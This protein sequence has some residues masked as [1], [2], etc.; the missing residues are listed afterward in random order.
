[1]IYNAPAKGED[2]LYFV[3][4]LNDNKR[5]CLIQLNN[6]KVADV[7]GEV[8]FELDSEVNLKKIEDTDAAN[9]MAANE[10]CETW[11]GK[12]LSENVVKGAYTSS[13]ADGQITGD[14]IEAT[15]IFNAQQ[16]VV[17]FE[18]LQPGKT[19]NV[20]LE[21]AGLWFAKKAFGS[22]WNVVQVKLHP[23]PILDVYPD[24]YAF[25]DEDEE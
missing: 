7:S 5:K 21:F 17:D 6:V 12:K 1:M 25:V 11:F 16:E 24:Q 15:K 14:R 10:N 9:L 4:A 22:A 13:V 20:I 19:C 8:V 2:G 3:K 23:D 18:T